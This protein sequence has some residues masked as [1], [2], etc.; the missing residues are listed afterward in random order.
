MI[1]PGTVGAWFA[2][3]EKGAEVQIRVRE[4]GEHVQESIGAP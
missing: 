1:A 3:A 2:F 4:G